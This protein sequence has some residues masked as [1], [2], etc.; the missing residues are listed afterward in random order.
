MLGSLPGAGP[1]NPR[2]TGG[3]RQPAVALGSG[4]SGNE[5]DGP[6]KPGRPARQLV[7]VVEALRDAFSNAD[8]TSCFFNDRAPTQMR[9]LAR[10]IVQAG[11]KLLAAKGDPQEEAMYE[12]VRKQCHV[13]ESGIKLFMKWQ[14]RKSLAA[15]VQDFATL[16]R[17]LSTFCGSSPRT[18]LNCRFLARLY[19]EVLACSSAKDDLA[20]ELQ[21]C[22]LAPLFPATNEA[23][24]GELQL[25]CVAQAVTFR[26]TA[27]QGSGGAAMGLGNDGAVQPIAAQPER[28]AALL[29]PFCDTTMADQFCPALVDQAQRLLLLVE[30]PIG[31]PFDRCAAKVLE[32]AL[33]ALPAATDD[34]ATADLTAMLVKYPTAGGKVVALARAKLA[35]LWAFIGYQDNVR[36]QTTALRA[37]ASAPVDDLSAAIDILRIVGTNDG[38]GQPVGP[39]QSA[40]AVGRDDGAAQP[41]G[42]YQRALDTHAPEDAG[43]HHGAV[44][45]AHLHVYKAFAREWAITM[46]PVATWEPQA[47][48]PPPAPPGLVEAARL[49]CAAGKGG[50]LPQAAG[51]AQS[52]CQAWLRCF[53]GGHLGA[54]VDGIVTAASQ[55][56]SALL[57]MAALG[58]TPAARLAW[59]ELRAIGSEVEAVADA[60]DKWHAQRIVGPVEHV[61]AERIRLPT[62]AITRLFQQ[63]SDLVGAAPPDLTALAACDCEEHADEVLEGSV[64]QWSSVRAQLM[65]RVVRASSQAA[66][67]LCGPADGGAASSLPALVPEWTEG[68]VQAVAKAVLG[69]AGQAEGLAAWAKGHRDDFPLIFHADSGLAAGE[70]ALQDVSDFVGGALAKV[71]GQWEKAATDLEQELKAKLPPAHLVDDPAILTD[72][73]LQAAFDVCIRKGNLLELVS[74]AKKVARLLRSVARDG[75]DL[76]LETPVGK[77][78][79]LEKAAAAG[80]RAIGAYFALDAIV[81]TVPAEPAEI[82]RHAQS[83]LTR[84]RAKGYGPTPPEAP[85]PEFYER[86]LQRML[87]VP[88]GAPE[89]PPVA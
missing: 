4:G 81:R 39:D 5:S 49:L 70:K 66:R 2:R 46:A 36:S 47:K 9:C 65:V 71:M 42:P 27:D 19:L 11:Q 64:G 63:V 79:S 87:Q 16:W 67:L 58:N 25:S 51:H 57:A 82:P 29:K 34:A 88:A 37:L 13:M 43:A 38:A 54:A 76:G 14:G 55:E 68:A 56:R 44:L 69:V 75:E 26:L 24:V 52:H 32:G 23:D 73:T 50:L 8:E 18:P 85:L 86:M 53:Q 6:R 40:R 74:R 72:T 59:S 35:D 7:P 41:V 80:K 33:G 15:G 60:L 10:Y 83:I 20:T 61:L 22:R 62:E 84:L 78:A 31:N 89:G 28:I 12:S 17:Q 1:R 3:A 30:P 77:A 21:R 48:P 45:A